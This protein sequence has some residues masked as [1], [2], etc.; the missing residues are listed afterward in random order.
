MA[1]VKGEGRSKKR[2]FFGNANKILVLSLVTHL[3]LSLE[4]AG[5]PYEIRLQRSPKF[6]H[7]CRH[8]EHYSAARS[9]FRD[10]IFRQRE[11]VH[12]ASEQ[13]FKLPLRVMTAFEPYYFEPTI[14]LSQGQHAK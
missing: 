8:F 9:C 12:V 13:A 3:S 14:I 5:F 7:R 4:S 10:V 6:E 2:T 1:T 11:F